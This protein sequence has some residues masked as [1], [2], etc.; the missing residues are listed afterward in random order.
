MLT[1]LTPADYQR[2]RWKNGQGWTTELAVRPASGRFDWRVSIA[3]VDADCEFST[4]P[5]VDRSILVL[6][7]EGLLLQVGAEPPVTLRTGGEPLAFPGD[8]PAHAR[9]IGGPT[10][11]FNVM[12][13]RGVFEHTLSIRPLDERLVLEQPAG[14]GW[15]IH[16][17]S[18]RAEVD[19]H[20]VAAGECALAEP[21]GITGQ[22]LSLRGSGVLVLVRICLPSH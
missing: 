13:R 6:S 15:L 9:L 21:A 10:R 1:V 19:A 5:G 11:D 14:S 3:D 17:A 7:G 18:G 22:Q 16:V 8:V 4:F 20:H 2:T 12:T